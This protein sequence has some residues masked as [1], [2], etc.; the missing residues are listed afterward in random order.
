MSEPVEV[1]EPAET[2]GMPPGLGRA[3]RRLWQET[4]DAWILAPDER[5]LVEQACALVDELAL[6]RRELIKSPATVEGSRGQVRPNPLWPIITEHRKTLRYLLAGL[7]TPAAAEKAEPGATSSAAQSL[8]M[9][10]WDKGR[11]G[12]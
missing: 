10:R 3:G 4:T 1:P 8:A 5:A 11:R 9:A 6:L 2:A 12:A 7:R